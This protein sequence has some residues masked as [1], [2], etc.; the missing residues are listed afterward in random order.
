M[1]TSA[2]IDE[3]IALGNNLVELLRRGRR[4]PDLTSDWIAHHIAECIVAARKAKGR[5]KVLAEERCV[6]TILQLWRHRAALP[7]G[8]RPYEKFEP[9][10]RMLARLD[11]DHD[12]WFYFEALPNWQQSGN[13]DAR[14]KPNSVQKYVE[15]AEKVDQSARILIGYLLDDAAKLADQPITRKLLKSG[16]GDEDAPDVE[17]VRQLLAAKDIGAAM[18]AAAQTAL[19]RRLAA[20]IDRLKGFITVAEAVRQEYEEKLSK[21]R[22]KT[23]GGKKRGSPKAGGQESG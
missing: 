23:P 19:E 21:L 9:I 10:L 16:I 13:P 2:K 1:E 14:P 15:L 17:T 6:A 8:R 11:P 5:A 12:H 4:Q 22:T 20:R 3:A 18:N 7:D